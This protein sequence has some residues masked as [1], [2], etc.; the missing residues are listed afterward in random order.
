MAHAWVREHKRYSLRQKASSLATRLPNKEK[1]FVGGTPCLSLLAF[2]FYLFSY[3]CI[4][5]L[6]EIHDITCL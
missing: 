5:L 2:M 1:R 3:A 4:L 6:L